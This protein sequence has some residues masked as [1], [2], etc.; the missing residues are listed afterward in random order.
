LIRFPEPALAPVIPPEIVPTDHVKLL[1]ILEFKEIFGLVP[2]QIVALFGLVTA[3]PG[4]TVTAIVYGVPIHE[5]AIEV[6][7]TM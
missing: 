1:G 5:P 2:L 4:L 3:G 6:A 7:V